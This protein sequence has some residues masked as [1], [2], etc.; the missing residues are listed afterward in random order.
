MI[1]LLPL[2]LA[3]A[4]FAAPDG[5]KVLKGLDPVALTEGKEV[6]G[7]PD[8]AID[9][10]GF[11]YFFASD[12]NRAKFE[13]DP[14]RFE[15]QFG[16]SCA[17]MGPMSSV[18]K[19]DH[20]AVHD[21]RIYVFASAD[22]R[23]GFLADPERHLDVVEEPLKAD[24]AAEARGRGLVDLALRGMGGA[25]KVDAVHALKLERSGPRESGG[26]TYAVRET[27]IWRFPDGFR[28]ESAWD[29]WVYSR[30][31]TESDAFQGSSAEDSMSPTGL[32]EF[33]R[34]MGREPLWILR[35]RTAKDFE[36]AAAGTEK[37]GDVEAQILRVR[38][39]GS[40]TNLYLDPKSG[41]ILRSAWK[42]RLDSGI[43]G[44]V[45]V[46][47]SDFRDV[48]GLT[49]AHAR[50]TRFDGKVY[51]DRSGPFTLVEIDPELPPGAFERTE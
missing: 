23:K 19:M 32:E 20:F 50:E 41:R 7:D 12:E 5:R 31:A 48:G 25:T 8:R 29:D 9:R 39:R 47:H 46:D 42:G 24:D 34:Q 38:L 21:G 43:R 45:V 1:L 3:L 10:D 4:F 36:L 11:R 37:V 13:A 49:L 6:A 18:C 22:C 51:A 30:V 14:K 27:S 15:I 40:V 35:H 44:E 26:K 16:G 17:R 33:H 2:F 28:T